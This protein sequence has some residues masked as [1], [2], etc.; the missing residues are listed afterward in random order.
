[1]Y[2]VFFESAG[3]RI[4]SL[5]TRI[6]QEFSDLFGGRKQKNDEHDKSYYFTYIHREFRR[7]FVEIYHFGDGDPQKIKCLVEKPIYEYYLTYSTW[8]NE[9]KKENSRLR[10]ANRKIGK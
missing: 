2:R 7:R 6:E 1:M 10:E 8:L 9:L 3:L 5:F 4:H